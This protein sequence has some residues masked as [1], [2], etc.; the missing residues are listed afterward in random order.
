[1]VSP[2]KPIEHPEGADEGGDRSCSEATGERTVA[3]V[4][5]V[6]NERAAHSVSAVPDGESAH[7][8][9]MSTSECTLVSATN[10]AGEEVA[11][12]CV[13]KGA[14]VSVEN[15]APKAPDEG[16]A[17]DCQE[18]VNADDAVTKAAYGDITISPP[19]PAES[20]VPNATDEGSAASAPKKARVRKR[21]PPDKSK[22]IPSMGPQECHVCHKIL[23]NK[24]VLRQHFRTHT[25]ERPFSCDF[26]PMKFTTQYGLV[27]HRRLHTGEKPYVCE[28]CDRRF[29]QWAS[30]QSHMAT[31]SAEKPHKCPVC[32]KGFARRDTLQ[33]HLGTHTG[34]RPY[35]CSVCPKTYRYRDTLQRHEQ[36]KHKPAS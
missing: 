25:G 21:K 6:A 1:M 15:S 34:E 18:T 35:C 10:C 12:N 27:V 4:P 3:S 14:D 9:S 16:T 19:E 22:P 17:G 32:E 24:A 2:Q 30:R 28:V 20:S 31:H 36:K 8:V 11:S 33:I 7:S 26:C 13:P 5:K 23:C 29:S